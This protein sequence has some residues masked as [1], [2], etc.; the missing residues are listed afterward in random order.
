MIYLLYG[1]K[2]YEI[3]K[4]IEKICQNT[5][6]MN[7]SKYDINTDQVKS[8]IDDCETYSLFAEN[9]IIIADNANMFTAGTNKDSD[10]IEEYINNPNPMATLIFIVH[11]EN[12]DKRKKITKQIT[13][14]GKILEFN[15]EINIEEFIK[16]L[17]KG[18][19][20]NHQNIKLLIDRVGSNPLIIE[21]EINKL[22]LYKNKDK[23]I[24]DEDILK[25][26]Y[27][28]IE[29]DIFKLI[30]NIVKNNKDKAI[31]IYQ[32]ML[33]TNKEP[34]KIVIMLANQF[35]IMY[36]SKELMK[37]GYS[38]KN[39]A[40]TLQIHPY[41]VKLAIQNSKAYDSKT[42]L[43]FIND[44]AEIDLNIKT[45]NANKDLALELF[46]LKL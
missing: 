29:T 30:D 33:K 17:L 24:T 43:K 36:Q 28:T 16:N 38:E 23:E 1:N 12:I 40:E 2:D 44:L 21:N 9:K 41:R 5:D 14:I 22:K 45:G 35:R 18:Y 11:N 39:I 32:E 3:N 27:K 31:E 15:S 6:K 46:I 4:E 7:I 19:T 20:I 26:T 8:I 42:L 13:K 25:A 37:K 10:L 34:L